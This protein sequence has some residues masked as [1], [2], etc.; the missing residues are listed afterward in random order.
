M[1]TGYSSFSKRALLKVDINRNL[2]KFLLLDNDDL[3]LTVVKCP[4]NL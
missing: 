1:I 3:M 2:L 4:L